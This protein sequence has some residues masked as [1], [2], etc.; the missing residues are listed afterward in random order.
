MKIAVVSGAVSGAIRTGRAIANSESDVKELGKDFAVGFA[1]GFKTAALCSAGCASV[2]MAS[3]AISGQIN[4]GFGWSA[5]KWQGGYQ[6]PKTP[7]VSIATYYGGKNGGRSFGVDIDIYK[8]VHYHTNKFG[9]GK[10]S[11][12]IKQHH[13]EAG[14]I[15]VGVAVGFSEA[16]SEW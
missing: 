2:S 10:R 16:E 7:G 14:A 11:D 12:W 1:D 8:G 5:G 6:T 15:F 3:Y 4:G 9:T 13:W